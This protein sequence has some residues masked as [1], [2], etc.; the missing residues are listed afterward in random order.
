[1]T[2]LQG[3]IDE[4]L[5]SHKT[6]SKYDIE[7]NDSNRPARLLDLTPIQRNSES[8]IRLI[9][10]A[11][12]SWYRYACLSHRWDDKVKQH[13]TTLATVSKSLD[14]LNLKDM[15]TNFR[16][17]IS[18]ARGLN[19]PY[20]WIDSI[21]IIQSGDDGRDLHTELAKMGSIFQNAYLTIAAVSS[22][23]SEGGCFIKEKWPDIC[24]SISTNTSGPH[25]MGARVLDKKG[26]KVPVEVFKNRFPLL[27]R[28]WVF[29]E[30]LLSPRL[31]QCNYG[32]F[33][34][35]C[36]ES[37]QCECSSGMA[38]HPARVGWIPTG[39]GVS[40]T[41]RQ[42][43][44][45]N[46]EGSGADL[47][48]TG[49]E[50]YWKDIVKEYMKLE[51]SKSSDVLPAIAGCAQA[52]ATHL[53]TT[54]IAGMWKKTLENE[55][56]WYVETQSAEAVLEPDL[57]GGYP[58]PRPEGSTAPSWSW[59]S[60][61][62]RQTI[63]YMGWRKGQTWTNSDPLLKKAIKEVHCE[64]ELVANPFGKLKEAY[65]KLDTLLYPWY[66]RLFCYESTREDKL[67]WNKDLHMERP[68][69]STK[70]TN[71][72]VPEL[73]LDGA[74][75]SLYLDA[76]FKEEGLAQERFSDC[77]GS[78][79]HPCALTP[80]YLLHALHRD[81]TSRKLDVFLLLKLVPPVN[82]KPN[83]YRRI[84]LMQVIN[85]QADVQTWEQM[86]QSRLK[87]SQEEFWLF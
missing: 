80:I 42:R 62:M 53:D 10:T 30:R 41:H 33:V 85:E 58:K 55:L 8:G 60:V 34:F 45:A 16:D 36:L 79:T 46:D 18:I 2:R 63:R 57:E 74:T 68:N 26:F 54:Y 69:R 78:P 82:G 25:V 72:K 75:V 24:F 14:F 28:A 56:L 77:T 76:R 27:N 17:S 86:I 6:C 81:T 48:A 50:D 39:A 15:P 31:L 38:P 11:S 47:K 67:K 66:L 61:S 87:P 22:P 5:R 59:A 84:G 12:G 64:P 52:L 13:K 83:C 51:L 49:W 7:Q 20:L 32:E 19:I 44:H 3:W 23:D 35:E 29:Q 1:M 65:L 40:S 37:S 9:E 73:A 21:C 43:L 70:C 71:A 4:C